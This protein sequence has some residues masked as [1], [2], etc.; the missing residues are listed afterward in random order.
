MEKKSVDLQDADTLSDKS[1]KQKIGVLAAELAFDTATAVLVVLALCGVSGVLL[2]AILCPVAGIIVAIY[3]LSLG[4]KRIGTAGT[5]L[6]KA[7]I[8]LT[9]VFLF[10]VLAVAGVNS[11]VENM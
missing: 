2:F 6:A 3:A 4:E 1:Q 10:I 11:M 9:C 8:A 7:T 5:A